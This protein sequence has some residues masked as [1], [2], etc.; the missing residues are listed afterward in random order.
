MTISKKQEVPAELVAMLSSLSKKIDRIETMIDS[1]N[2]NLEKI[3]MM[4]GDE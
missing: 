3:R 4:I 1:I 2:E